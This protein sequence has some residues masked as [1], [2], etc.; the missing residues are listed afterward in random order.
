MRLNFCSFLFMIKWGMRGWGGCCR[1]MLRGALPSNTGE[2]DHETVCRGV[3]CRESC[4]GGRAG[5]DVNEVNELK[6]LEGTY[7]VALLEKDGKP[8]EKQIKDNVKF[9]FQGDVLT[10]QIKDEAKKAKIKVDAVK[11]PHTIDITPTD[12]TE[13]GKTFPGIYKAEKGEVTLAFTEKPNAD[14]PKNFKSDENT[15]LVKLEKEAKK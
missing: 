10:I 8:A 3:L 4:R 13:K 14:R 7:S 5:A 11:T 12:G 6:V 9:V 1:H 2:S 15:V